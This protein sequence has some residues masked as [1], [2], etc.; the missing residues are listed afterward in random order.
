LISISHRNTVNGRD[1]TDKTSKYGIV[2]ML[3]KKE[4][5]KRRKVNIYLTFYQVFLKGKIYNPGWL[6]CG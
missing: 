5:R 2:Q 4:K 3:Y 6:C 1:N